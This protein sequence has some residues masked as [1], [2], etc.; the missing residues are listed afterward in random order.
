MAPNHKSGEETLAG[1]TR[2]VHV[3]V[4]SVGASKDYPSDECAWQVTHLLQETELSEYGHCLSGKG[5]AADFVT[6]KFG[7]VQEEGLEAVAFCIEGGGGAGWATAYDDEVVRLATCCHFETGPKEIT[8][9]RPRTADRGQQNE[10]L[11]ALGLY[12]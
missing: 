4:R 1:G 2:K 3:D 11:A 8:D 12:A 10:S 7:F 9:D 5:I 6:R